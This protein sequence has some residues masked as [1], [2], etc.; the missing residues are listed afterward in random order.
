[1]NYDESKNKNYQAV[2]NSYNYNN[3]ENSPQKTA[4]KE[5]LGIKNKVLQFSGAKN[6]TDARTLA[7]QL[8]GIRDEINFIKAGYA[9]CTII[10]RANVFRVVLNSEEEM[11]CYNYTKKEDIH[12]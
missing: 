12:E 9:H 4:E 11:I 3:L 1:M 10:N 7:K 5:Y 8:F 6:I 2:Y